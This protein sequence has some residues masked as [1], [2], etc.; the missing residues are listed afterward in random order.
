MSLSAAAASPRFGLGC[1]AVAAELRRLLLLQQQ[2]QQQQVP[3]R[4]RTVSL[5]PNALAPLHKP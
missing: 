5:E 3:L 2:Q 1:A 4:R